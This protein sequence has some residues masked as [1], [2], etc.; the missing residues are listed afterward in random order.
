MTKPLTAWF[1]DVCGET[2]DAENGYVVWKTDENLKSHYFKIIHQDRCDPDGDYHSS[3]AL[4][5][6]LGEDGL[7]YLLSHLSV[8][9]II[10]RRNRKSL[11]DVADIDEYVDFIRRVQ[12]PYYEEARQKFSDSEVREDFSDANEV[13]PYL[14]QNLKRIASD[15]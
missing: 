10:L 15:Y 6:F 9:P 8:G 3:A 12:T 7:A 2:V 5:D 13:S 4:K 14:P 11:C 1:C